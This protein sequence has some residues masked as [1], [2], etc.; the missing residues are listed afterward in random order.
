MATVADTKKLFNC[1][2]QLNIYHNMFCNKEAVIK[3]VKDCSIS[4]HSNIDC[5][6][7]IKKKQMIT[8]A[9]AILKCK[10]MGVAVPTLYL[11][12]TKNC[13]IIME[14]VSGLPI[15]T[16][17]KDN[18]NNSKLITGV[19]FEIGI[20]LS[21]LHESDVSHGDLNTSNMLIKKNGSIVLIN[22]GL[23]CLDANIYEKVLD[24]YILE[25]SFIKMH[26][27]IADKFWLILTSYK[28]FND[29]SMVYEKFNQLK[30]KLM[31]GL[32]NYTIV[33]VCL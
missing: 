14:N 6:L 4:S 11:I 9:K 16:F 30:T 28:E 12:D 25:Q 24:L 15:D 21:K 33:I 3:M 22:F 29:S 1:N 31:V 27:G 20:I 17:L 8:E 7:K 32:P 2:S 5:I 23:S 10:T 19:L 18:D 13:K 26:W